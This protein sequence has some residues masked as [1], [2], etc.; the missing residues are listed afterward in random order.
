MVRQFLVDAGVADDNFYLVDGCGLSN[1]DKISLSGGTRLLS[2]ASKQSW[3]KDDAERCLSRA[4]T[5]RWI[6]AGQIPQ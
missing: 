4:S 3:G 5:A 2:Y 1:D 6:T